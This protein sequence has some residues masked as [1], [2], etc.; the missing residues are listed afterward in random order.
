MVKYLSRV[1]HDFDFVNAYAPS[2]NHFFKLMG[3]AAGGGGGH[4]ILPFTQWQQRALAY[5]AAHPTS[6]LARIAAVVDDLTDKS[7]SAMLKGLPV[8]EH[9]FGGDVY[10]VPLVDEQLVQKSRDR[11]NAVPAVRS[12]VVGAMYNEIDEWRKLIDVKGAA[13]LDCRDH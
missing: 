12:T 11:I 1:G 3:A 2:C 4:D 5:A 6:P 7:A 8:R 13:G 10:P 9:V